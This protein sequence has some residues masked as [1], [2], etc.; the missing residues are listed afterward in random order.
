MGRFGQFAFFGQRNLVKLSGQ[1]SLVDGRMKAFVETAGAE[2]GKTF[3]S[4]GDYFNRDTIIGLFCHDVM[5]QGVAFDFN[6]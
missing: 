2:S 6:A 5:M 1:V 3:F 4:L